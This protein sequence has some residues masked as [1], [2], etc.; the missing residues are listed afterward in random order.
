MPFRFV[1]ST[2]MRNLIKVASNVDDKT[3]QMP[4]RRIVTNMLQ[5]SHNYIID[6]VKSELGDAP[7]TVGEAVIDCFLSVYIYF[8]L[9]K[10]FKKFLINIL[11]IL[12]LNITFQ[13]NFC[14]FAVYDL[15]TQRRLIESHVGVLIC[16]VTPN[17]DVTIINIYFV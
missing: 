11:K 12:Y 10:K 3:L 17:M 1:E 16:Y 14:T 7:I 9:K 4:N 5:Y 15:W 8:F 13:N 2:A 6:F